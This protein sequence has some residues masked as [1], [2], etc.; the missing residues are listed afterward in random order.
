MTLN[1]REM[2]GI[3]FLLKGKEIP[4]EVIDTKSIGAFRLHKN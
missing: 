3:I 1:D 4:T 2:L